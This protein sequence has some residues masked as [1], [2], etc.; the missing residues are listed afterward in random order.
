MRDVAPKCERQVLVVGP[1]WVGDMVMSQV[2]YQLLHDERPGVQID[3]LAPAWSEPILARMPQI[4]GAL[5]NPVRH[6]E[7]ALGKRWKQ[8]RELRLECYEQAIVL[9][10]SLK[11]ALVPCFAAVPRRTGWRGEMRYGLLN[12]MRELDEEKLPQMVQRFAALGL[13]EGVGLPAELPAPRLMVD[14]DSV[15]SGRQ[16]FLLAD[17]RPILA[18]CPGAEFG[19]AKRWPLEYYADLAQRYLQRGWQVLLYGSQNDSEVTSQIYHISGAQRY[20]YDLAGKTSLA[21][22]IDLLSLSDAVVSNDSGLMHIAAALGRP[23]L[24]LYGATSPVFTPPLSNVARMI[25][26]DIECAPCFARECPLGHH[27]CMRDITADQAEIRLESLLISAG[28]S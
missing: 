25:V 13:D 6:G 5:V 22:A 24:V 11:S 10:S 16:K 18:L 26:S 7:L 12:D 9:P 17:H 1:S 8:G 14:Q 4:N 20:C 21:E 2:L 19:G 23:L 28:D 15:A 27:R 3:V